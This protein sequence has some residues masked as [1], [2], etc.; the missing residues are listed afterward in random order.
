MW[1]SGEVIG[2][3]MCD[4]VDHRAEVNREVFLAARKTSKLIFELETLFT[5][6]K[7]D[8]DQAQH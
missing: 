8:D 1:T 2:V 7:K 3:R 6:E 5:G 4:R